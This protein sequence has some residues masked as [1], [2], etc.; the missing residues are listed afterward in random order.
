LKGEVCCEV[1]KGN[2]VCEE[3]L[4]KKKKKEWGGKQN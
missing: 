4:A 2:W 1:K 3:K